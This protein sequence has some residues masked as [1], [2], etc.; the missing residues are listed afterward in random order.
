M[1]WV[2]FSPLI[3]ISFLDFLFEGYFYLIKLHLETNHTIFFC[4]LTVTTL[5]TAENSN[6]AS[7]AGLGDREPGA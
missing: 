7:N 4:L 2:N 6:N 3:W 5:C 1:S